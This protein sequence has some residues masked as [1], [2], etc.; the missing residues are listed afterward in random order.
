MAK[1][2]KY[3]H[4]LPNLPLAVSEHEDFDYQQKINAVKDR[5][6]GTPIESSITIATAE[7][8]IEA[9]SEEVS[10]SMKTVIDA[11]LVLCNGDKSATNLA[12]VYGAYRKAREEFDR[13]KS[14]L[15]IF[16]EALTQLM[17]AA[18]EA[19]GIKGI[20]LAEGGL[21]SVNPDLYGKVLD[22]E[23]YLQWIIDNGYRSK[24]NVP[25]QTTNAIVGERALAGEPEPDGVETKR[26]MKISYRKG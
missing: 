13:Q 21:V 5:M 25:W 19:E 9:E 2:T 1:P 4:I 12:N 14:N 11:L 26:R 15:D 18:F 16:E 17:E 20:R 3:A 22:K 10:D 8:N 24:I 23:K 6:T 7:L